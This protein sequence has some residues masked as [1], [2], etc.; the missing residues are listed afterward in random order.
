MTQHDVWIKR[1]ASMVLLV[2]ISSAP[3]Y[4][5][6]CFYDT[7]ISVISEKYGVPENVVAEKLPGSRKENMQA[8]SRIFAEAVKLHGASYVLSEISQQYDDPV[9]IAVMSYCAALFEK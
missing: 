6:S 1:T 3:G 5:E 4:A 2:L 9:D 7:Y 8:T